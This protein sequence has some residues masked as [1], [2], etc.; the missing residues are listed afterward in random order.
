MSLTLG[1]RVRRLRNSRRWSQRELAERAGVSQQAIAQLERN[2]I[3][4]PKFVPQ[5]AEAFGL[6]VRDLERESN[7]VV[8][9]NPDHMY[10]CIVAAHE[11]LEGFPTDDIEDIEYTEIVLGCAIYE[12]TYSSTSSNITSK[13]LEYAAREAFLRFLTKK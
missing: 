6:S 9:I 11:V 1:E 12:S 3:T 7:I 13:G 2:A 10:A 5:I 8:G 4:K